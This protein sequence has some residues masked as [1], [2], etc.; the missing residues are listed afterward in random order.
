MVLTF[1]VD[2][3]V[4]ILLWRVLQAST[5]TSGF[6][7]SFGLPRLL[8]SSTSTSV[9]DSSSGRISDSDFGLQVFD[10]FGLRRRALTRALGFPAHFGGCRQHWLVQAWLGRRRHRWRV[11]AMGARERLNREWTGN[12]QQ[13]PCQGSS[14]VNESCYTLQYIL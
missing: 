13:P 2:S 4:E 6:D 5:H 8:W 11:P 14:A 9:F 10:C 12:L 3:S 1:T 7:W